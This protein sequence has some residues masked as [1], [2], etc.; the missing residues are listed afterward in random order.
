M[1]CGLFV[2]AARRDMGVRCVSDLVNAIRFEQTWVHLLFFFG[3]GGGVGLRIW[4]IRGLEI[5][6]TSVALRERERRPE[7]DR[8]SAAFCD[9]ERERV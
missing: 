7:M 1:S 4:K 2:L 8:S 9:R 3:G 5:D 6:R